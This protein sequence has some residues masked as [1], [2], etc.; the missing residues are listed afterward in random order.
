LA[1]VSIFAVRFSILNST[2]GQVPGELAQGAR[3]RPLIL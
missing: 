3:S 1:Y 2:P